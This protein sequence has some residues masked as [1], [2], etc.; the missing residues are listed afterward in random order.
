[1]QLAQKTALPSNSRRQVLS[2]ISLPHTAPVVP[3]KP[4]SWQQP[5]GSAGVGVAVGVGVRVTQLPTSK[6]KPASGCDEHAQFPQKTGS[7]SN[8]LWQLASVTSF[9]Q[10]EWATPRTL[11]S[12]Q[13]PRGSGRVGVALGVGVSVGVAVCGAGP[14]THRRVSVSHRK[15]RK[16]V[17]AGFRRVHSG[18]VMSAQRCCPLVA[19]S[20]GRAKN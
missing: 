4:V 11:F 13:Q 3:R 9:P 15:R 12:W 16:N 5:R 17:L 18:R 2:R 8:S 20:V 7:P 6:L 10:T 14:S 1:M 19:P